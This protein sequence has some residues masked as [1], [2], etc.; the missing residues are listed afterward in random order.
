MK[1]FYPVLLLLLSIPLVAQT[2]LRISPPGRIFYPP[3]YNTQSVATIGRDAIVLFGSTASDPES[4][5]PVQVL[6]V[7][8]LR[9]GQPS[10]EQRTLGDAAS[11]PT[12]AA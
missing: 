2:D 9:N 11:R 8:I 7:Q 12:G 3:Q 4:N 5:G 10:G 1:I 6:R